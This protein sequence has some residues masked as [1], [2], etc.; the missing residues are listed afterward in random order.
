MDFKT[1][2]QEIQTKIGYGESYDVDLEIKVLDK[3][4]NL[5]FLTGLVDSLQVIE[6]VKG[7]LKIP[8]T[9][10][11]VDDLIKANLAHHNCTENK[12]I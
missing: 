9:K 4:V 5:Y 1:L 12:R 2:N 10:S 3:Q 8:R 11:V 7:I 6:I